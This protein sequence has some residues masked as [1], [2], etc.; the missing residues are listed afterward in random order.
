MAD[1]EIIIPHD[2][3]GNSQTITDV[4]IRKFKERGLDIHKHE[5]VDLTDDHSK[6]VRR[7][8]IRNVKYFGPWRHR[9]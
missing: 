6:G 2:E 7:L 3:I 4:N 9:G 8:K 5:V 1:K